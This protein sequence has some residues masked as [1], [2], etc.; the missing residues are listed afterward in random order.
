MET[1]EKGVID[2]LFLPVL[3]HWTSVLELRHGRENV[4]V[5]IGVFGE[6]LEDVGDA[7]TSC[8]SLEEVI[9][10]EKIENIFFYIY[11][12]EIEIISYP[13]ASL[14]HVIRGLLVKIPLS[15]DNTNP[16]SS[17]LGNFRVSRLI[18]TRKELLKGYVHSHAEKYTPDDRYRYWS[19]ACTGSGSTFDIFLKMCENDGISEESMSIYLEL[20]D[21]WCR[22]ESIPGGP[23]C[24]FEDTIVL[25]KAHASKSLKLRL[26]K[27]LHDSEELVIRRG[28][29]LDGSNSY[30]ANLTSREIARG[31][32]EKF[33]ENDEDELLETRAD[34]SVCSLEYTGHNDRRKLLVPPFSVGGR[35]IHPEVIDEPGCKVERYP[36]E[37]EIER[38]L[39]KIMQLFHVQKSRK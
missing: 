2:S 27:Y 4:R 22:T 13:N 14:R 18:M 10:D 39:E 33:G 3:Q 23:Y 5:D 20:L 29:A 24:R 38:I 37:S 1:N 25:S 31:L 32:I 15:F 16:L 9:K 30:I 35:I 17:Y 28:L 6:M 12:P 26:L 21:S 8:K 19:K 11:I 7:I 34:G 36:S